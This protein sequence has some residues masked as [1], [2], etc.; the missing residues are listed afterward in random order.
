MKFGS[1]AVCGMIVAS[2]WSGASMAGEHTVGQKD[3][4]FTQES[5]SVSVGDTVHFQNQDPF[6]HNVY[7]LS[8]ASTFDLGSYPEGESKSV[9]FDTPGMIEV[10][11]A[12]HPSMTM[13]IDVK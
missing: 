13:T 3:K 7:S 9:T 2:L 11:C 12:V 5:L 6:F 10:E 8:D 1:V 4:A